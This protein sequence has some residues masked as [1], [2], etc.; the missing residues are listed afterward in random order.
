MEARTYTSTEARDEFSDLVNRAAYGHEWAVI[1][2]RGREIAAIVSIEDLHLL[3][4]FVEEA[5]ARLDAEE[6]EGI[7][8]DPVEGERIPWEDVKKQQGL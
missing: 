6:A 7:L 2:R 3:A 1:H 8:N 4:R 5:S